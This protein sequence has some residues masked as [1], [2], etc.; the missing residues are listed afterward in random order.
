MKISYFVFINAHIEVTSFTRKINYIIRYGMIS[1]LSKSACDFVNVYEKFKVF[2]FA[3][4]SYITYNAHFVFC[5]VCRTTGKFV[6][7]TLI[8][9]VI[10]R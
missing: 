7:C 3:D 6:L 9:Y 1:L 10:P 8:N 4:F 5:V 2:E